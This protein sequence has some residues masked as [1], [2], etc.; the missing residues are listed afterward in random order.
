M[1]TG[2]EFIAR[3]CVDVLI[4]AIIGLSCIFGWRK[5]FASVLFSIFSWIFCIV[6]AIVGSYPFKTY[7]I[8][9]TDFDD[10]ISAH[11]KDTL[12]APST[13]GKFFQSVPEQ[14][15]NGFS[16]YQQSIAGRMATSITDRL[17]S[18]ISFLLIIIALF[19]ITK[20]IGFA[21]SHGKKRGPIGIFNGILGFIFG[22]LRGVFI[23]SVVMLGLFPMLSFLDPQAASPIVA[24]IR[25]SFLAEL[26]YDHNPI[27]LMF[28]MF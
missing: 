7:L 19:L 12:L 23:I 22:A 18:I 6:A 8:E 14:I 9:N 10:T 24:G 2:P 13:G 20:L 26:F 16:G 28:E 21:I 27:S 1:G 11:V 25:E 15:Q 4:V 3:V 17:M 5:G